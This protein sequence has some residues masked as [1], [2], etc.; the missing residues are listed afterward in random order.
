[1]KR[2]QASSAGGNKD[3]NTLSL[4]GEGGGEEY[5]GHLRVWFTMPG[6]G[7]GHFFLPELNLTPL[8]NTQ[9]YTEQ[10]IQDIVFYPETH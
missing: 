2:Q 9:G 7:L 10:V 8:S 4:R 3:H 1:M 6:L 5:N